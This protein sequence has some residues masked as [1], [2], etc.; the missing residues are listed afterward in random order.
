M[1]SKKAQPKDDEQDDKPDTFDTFVPDNLVALELGGVS[2]M[3]LYRW[4]NDPNIDF[5]PPIKMNGR[6]YRSR[7]KIE[8]FKKRLQQQALDT[9]KKTSRLRT[10]GAVR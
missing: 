9:H 2:L 6:N 8:R 4:S 7:R 3:T 5:P 1:Q 10:S